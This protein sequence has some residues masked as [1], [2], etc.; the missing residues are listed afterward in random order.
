M[1]I[2][3]GDGRENRIERVLFKATGVQKQIGDKGTLKMILGISRTAFT[4]W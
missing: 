3:P 4:A 2:Y 1:L